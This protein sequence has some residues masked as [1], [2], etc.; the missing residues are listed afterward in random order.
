MLSA[1][2]GN[3]REILDLLLSIINV[4]VH[5]VDIVA[6]LPKLKFDGSPRESYVARHLGP[7]FDLPLRLD[8]IVG[9]VGG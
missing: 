5:T 6:S 3:P 1:D 2:V 4:S 9:M 8:T 7:L